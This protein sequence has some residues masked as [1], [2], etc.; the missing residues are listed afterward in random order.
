MHQ[1]RRP[2]VHH[3]PVRD[4]DRRRHNYSPR[5][6]RRLSIDRRHRRGADHHERELAEIARREREAAWICA[7]AEL[8]AQ[9][10]RERAAREAIPRDDGRI[11]RAPIGRDEFERDRPHRYQRDQ[12]RRVEIHQYHGEELEDRG[13]RVLREAIRT[14]AERVPRRRARNP[15]PELRRWD[16]GIYED[17]RLRRGS[18]R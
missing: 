1:P 8:R 13:E 18:W 16:D 12:M 4:H 15:S 9:R 6:V 7:E 10:R 17:D 2:A 14:E 11:G 3:P 5:P